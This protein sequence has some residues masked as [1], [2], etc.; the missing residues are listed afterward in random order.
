M[1]KSVTLVIILYIYMFECL[2][3]MALDYISYDL[4]C[5]KFCVIKSE[6]V[7]NKYPLLYL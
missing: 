6:T 5:H 3:D 2:V 1:A 7:S 4:L